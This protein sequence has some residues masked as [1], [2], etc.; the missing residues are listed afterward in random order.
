MSRGGEEVK[1][2]PKEHISNGITKNNETNYKYKKLV[3]IFKY[4]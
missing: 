4:M 3:Q 2:Y 1:N